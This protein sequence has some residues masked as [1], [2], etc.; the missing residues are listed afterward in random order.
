MRESRMKSKL[1]KEALGSHHGNMKQ[2]LHLMERHLCQLNSI[3][4]WLCSNPH[5]IH[6]SSFI[7]IQAV[8]GGSSNW[9]CVTNK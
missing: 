5:S 1:G 7:V 6:A 8:D 4:K 2:A 9:N 3:W